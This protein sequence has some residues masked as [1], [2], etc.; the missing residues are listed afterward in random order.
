MKNGKFIISLDFE[1]Q[2][3]MMDKVNALSPYR[4][5]ISR[6]HEIVPRLLDT[7]NK[8]NVKA[9]FAQV[10]MSFFQ[11]YQELFEFIEKRRCET[12]EKELTYENNSLSAYSHLDEIEKDDEKYFFANHL[13]KLIQ[14]DRYHEIASHTFSHYYC[15]EPGQTIAQFEEDCRRAN[16]I[17]RENDIHL[18]SLVFPR[19]QVNEDYLSVCAKYGYKV[20]RSNEE[21]WMY[22][23]SNGNDNTLWK[24]LFRLIDAYVNLSGHNSYDVSKLKIN[25][26]VVLLPASRFLRSFSKSLSF[27]EGLRLRRIKKDMTYAAKRGVIF[28]LW[29][30][31]H[32][33][34]SNTNENF[35]FLGKIL[36]Y[37]NYL[38]EKYNFESCSMSDIVKL[39]K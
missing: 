26:D 31:P 35:I 21:S 14:R 30:H 33:F 34:G 25:K 8:Y 32:N 24:R 1:L 27:L 5:N 3:G 17:A 39:L 22:Q 37:Y 6:V 11:D 7:F 12:K 16:L 2:W 13:L 20:V 18:K 19:N 36:E 23:A 9:T 15:L 29:W 4:K 10:G 38:H 28:H